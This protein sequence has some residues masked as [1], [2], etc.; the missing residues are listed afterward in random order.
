MK[1]KKYLIFIMVVLLAISVMTVTACNNNNSDEEGISIDNVALID[2]T[3]LTDGAYQFN[4]Y[5]SDDQIVQSEKENFSLYICDRAD[6]STSIVF[7]DDFATIS[8]EDGSVSFTY[9]NKYAMSETNGVMLKISSNA[10]KSGEEKYCCVRQDTND[11]SLTADKKV[12]NYY[13]DD[14]STILTL[15]G[16]V[17]T[18][19]VEKSDI[20][21][22]G[23]LSGATY[24]LQKINE[25]TLELSFSDAFSG[26]IATAGAIVL[27]SNAIYG[28]RE[29]DLT[30][31]FSVKKDSLWIDSKSTQVINTT[32]G[33]QVIMAIAADEG[34]I[35]NIGLDDV[36]VTPSELFSV[37][38]LNVINQNTMLVTLSTTLTEESLVA[39][40]NEMELKIDKSACNLGGNDC[41]LTANFSS[42]LVVNGYDGEEKDGIVNYIIKGQLINAKFISSVANAI[43]IK[44]VGG[45]EVPFE[46]L[47][48]TDKEF[49]VIIASSETKMDVNVTVSPEA[50][51]ASVYYLGEY[52]SKATL[53]HMDESRFALEAFLI[54]KAQSALGSILESVAGVAKEKISSFLTPKIYKL[55]GIEQTQTISMED[56]NN[57]ISEVSNDL[58]SLRGEVLTM[59]KTIINAINVSKYE[60]ALSGYDRDYGTLKQIV[61]ELFDAGYS[62][63]IK[64]EAGIATD[65][66]ITDEGLAQ[67]ET[68]VNADEYN[69]ACNSF[70]SHFEK[71]TTASQITNFGNAL[72]SSVAG[73]S[74]GYFGAYWEL[75]QSYFMF[76]SQCEKLMENFYTSTVSVYTLAINMVLRYYQIKG[77]TQSINA[78]IESIKS[79]NDGL[80]PYE[81]FVKE[82][83]ERARNGKTYDFTKHR[84]VSLNMGEASV[85]KGIYIS[86]NETKYYYVYDTCAFTKSEWEE[87]INAAT[88]R[89]LTLW[90][91]MADAG[92]TG[93]KSLKADV[94]KLSVGGSKAIGFALACSY[95]TKEVLLT[96]NDWGPLNR[97]HYVYVD[98]FAITA[99]K[100]QPKDNKTDIEWTYKIDKGLE[101]T[102]GNC[103]NMSTKTRYGTLKKEAPFKDSLGNEIKMYQLTR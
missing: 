100:T 51:S 70:V 91:T 49:S 32:S 80:K 47:S 71:V 5:F 84:V 60:Q 48:A 85:Q 62:K 68:G 77:Y 79:V 78:T 53:V 83:K 50:V 94:N 24:T 57:K 6:I 82:A 28:N 66:K 30:V 58:A 15:N 18:E 25:N 72:V 41:K 44:K 39:A 55:L 99:K 59:E 64:L 26:K 96:R 42:E 20:T 102:I 97:Y 87:L 73:L 4:L 65:G 29:K 95:E 46:L 7:L 35:A 36:S 8:E 12:L 54:D 21:L 43:S 81:N 14:F 37:S 2:T 19:T 90:E 93:F 101:T 9:V 89:G 98:Y 63:M 22:E 88:N 40:L 10:L 61:V 27:S 1:N 31:T 16:A 17:F 33:S 38:N 13:E 69:A 75:M 23:I 52:T 74:N 45:E 67:L 11:Y 56:L 103:Y 76:D 3:K 86:K 92:F 34:A